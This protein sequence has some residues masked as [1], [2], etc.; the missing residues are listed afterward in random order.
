[1]DVFDFIYN[2]ANADKFSIAM[3]LKRKSHPTKV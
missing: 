3:D 1:M 2:P